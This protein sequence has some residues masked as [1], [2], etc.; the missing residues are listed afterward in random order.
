MESSCAMKQSAVSFVTRQQPTTEE[1]NMNDRERN[2]RASL[3]QCGLFAT[4]DTV[5]E[6]A[7]YALE[8]AKAFRKAETIYV[9][10]AVQV[11]ANT[12]I[13]NVMKRFH[14]IEKT[15]L[16]HYTVYGTF[17]NGNCTMHSF[18]CQAEDREHAVEQ[19]LGHFETMSESPYYVHEVFVSDTPIAVCDD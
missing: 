12:I 15:E 14:L 17:A 1:I 3:G 16:Q 2:I 13:D 4:R 11:M 5:K 18:H 19:A 6:A 10:T 9:I 7:D 8:I